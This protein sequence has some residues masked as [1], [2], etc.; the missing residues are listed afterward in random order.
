[1][2][3]GCDIPYLSKSSRLTRPA[4]RGSSLLQR[5]AHH[6]VGLRFLARDHAVL[7]GVEARERLTPLR[8]AEALPAPGSGAG[9]ARLR[10]RRRFARRPRRTPASRRRRRE[11][12]RLSN[13]VMAAPR[14]F[15]GDGSRG[16]PFATSLPRTDGVP[17]PMRRVVS[18]AVALRILARNDVDSAAADGRCDPQCSDSV[19]R[20]SAQVAVDEMQ[21]AIGARGELGIVRDDHEAVPTARLSS[22]IR[23]NTCARGAAVEV[24]GRLVGEHA[25][26]LRD[27]RARERDAL[28]LAARELAGQVLERDAPRPTRSS[29]ASRRARAP[30]PAASRRIDERHRDVLQRGEFR[31][32]MMELVDEA[33]RAVAHA[34][35]ARLPTA[36]RTARRRR[37]T[38]PAVGASRPPSRCSSVLLPEPDAPTIATRSPRATARSTPSSTGTSSGPLRRSCASPRH[39]STG[40]PRGAGALTHSAAPRPD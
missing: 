8:P 9:L 28:A 36:S 4:F 6:R 27:E 29:I 40:D 1:M 21:R 32:Q 2:L 10:R 34:R 39:S 18:Q 17:F 13:V 11:L 31:Q 16:S 5:V 23:S 37:C 12:S 22:S 3:G 30:R 14:E 24:A 33:E 35:R 25:A 7:V 26:R 19:G 15:S 38:S 20:T